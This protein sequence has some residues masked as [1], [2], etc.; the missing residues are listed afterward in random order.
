[1]DYIGSLDHFTERFK[2]RLTEMA[3]GNTELVVRV[4]VIQVLETID[5]HSLL[6]DE[7]RE[8]LCFD[9]EPKVRGTT[10]LT[11]DL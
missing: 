5:G 11:K 2:P 10:V 9:E 4:A 1:M 8:K 3:T 6:E 7:E